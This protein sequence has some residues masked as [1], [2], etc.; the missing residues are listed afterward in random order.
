M[1]RV[2]CRSIDMS[3][4]FSVEVWCVILKETEMALQVQQAIHGR[5]EKSDPVWIPRSQLDHISKKG[6]NKENRAHKDA[7]ITMPSWLAET[8]GINYR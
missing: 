3:N 4:S 2:G 7:T 8:K 6:F 5:H 1:F